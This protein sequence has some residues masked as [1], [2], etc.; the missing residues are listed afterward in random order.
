MSQKVWIK[1]IVIFIFLISIVI[2]FYGFFHWN[3][4]VNRLRRYNETGELPIT[5]CEG[6]VVSSD[7]RIFCGLPDY[8]KIQ[9]YDTE[10]KFLLNFPIDAGGGEFAMRINKDDNLEVGTTRNDMLFVFDK[11]GKLLESIQAEGVI[12]SFNNIPRHEFMSNN[13]V[14]KIKSPLFYPAIVKIMP[15]NGKEVVLVSMDVLTWLKTGPN[16][17][18]LLFMIIA[19][20]IGWK[21]GILKKR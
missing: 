9:V 2:C 21:L 15:N 10:G 5:R 3:D 20:F 17:L 16:F 7:G 8:R 12:E 6:I 18:S 13:V 14:Y 4:F 19:L 1:I 11:S